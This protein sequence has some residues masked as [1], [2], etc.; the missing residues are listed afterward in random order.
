MTL[1]KMQVL[2][3]WGDTIIGYTALLINDEPMKKIEGKMKLTDGDFIV[4]HE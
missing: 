1:I 4:F 2:F 3:D